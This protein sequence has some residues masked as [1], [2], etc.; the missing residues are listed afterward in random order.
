[1]NTNAILRKLT[2]SLAI[3]R[4]E[5]QVW[6]AAIDVELEPAEVDALL[7]PESSPASVD[8]PQY[9][10]LQLLNQ[11]IVQQRGQKPEASVEVV[12]KQTKLSNND[13]LKKLR[14]A[15]Q[16]HEQDVRDLLR[17]VTIELTKSDLSALFRKAG[18]PQY[19][20]CDDELVLDFIEGL[21]LWL[22]RPIST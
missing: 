20:A 5:L 18:H 2:Q 10:L 14:I 16:L 21:G 1:M 19:K 6:F 8:L 22:A 4:P 15:Y 11:W 17:L 7:V 9:L 12:N 3:S 13:V